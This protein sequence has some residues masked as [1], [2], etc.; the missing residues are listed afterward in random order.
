MGV[1]VNM[2]AEA[3]AE[4]G[5]EEEETVQPSYLEQTKSAS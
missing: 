4:V 3:E 2:L 5:Q 1:L